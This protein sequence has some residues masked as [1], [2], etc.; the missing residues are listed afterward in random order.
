[1]PGG[2]ATPVDTV[3]RNNPTG[4]NTNA[5]GNN[6]GHFLNFCHLSVWFLLMHEYLGRIYMLYII[7]EIRIHETCSN[8]CIDTLG[9]R[10]NETPLYWKDN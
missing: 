1:M 4:S 9:V 2:I 3:S 5:G 6:E 10:C 7:F 8:L